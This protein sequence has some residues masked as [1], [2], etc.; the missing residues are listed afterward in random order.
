MDPIEKAR[1][2]VY[3]NARPLELARWQYHFENGDKQNV[4]QALEVYQNEDGGFGYGLEPDNWNPNS[5]PIAT[6]MACNILR[7]IDSLDSKNPLVKGILAYLSS[8]KD[9]SQGK[10]FKQVPS[11]IDYPHAIWWESAKGVPSDNPTVS[12]AGMILVTSEKDSF[13]YQKAQDII[14]Q[15]VTDFVEE[16]TNEMHTLV[17]Y[18]EMLYYCEEADFTFVLNHVPFRELLKRQIR[19]T[20][21]PDPEAWFTEYVSKPSDYFLIKNQV[22]DILDEEICLIETTKIL[23][24]QL[25]DGSFIVPWE[26]GNEYSEFF[27]SRQWWKSIIIIKNFLFLRNF[28]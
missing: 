4:L 22:L 25:E 18:L 19:Q 21:A 26:W 20:V 2:F 12:L 8:E 6:W 13:L 16:P 23:E 10:W 27:I 11:T 14:K 28:A 17:V 7:E 3:Q 15:A 5:T 1:V 9:F 24:N